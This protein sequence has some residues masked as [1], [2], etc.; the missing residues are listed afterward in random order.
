MFFIHSFKVP[1]LVTVL[2]AENTAAKKTDKYMFI[3][4]GGDIQ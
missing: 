3:L 4:I 1:T 2:G